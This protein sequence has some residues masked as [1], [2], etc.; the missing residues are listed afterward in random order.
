MAYYDWRHRSYGPRRVL[1]GS[2]TSK[3]E[4]RSVIP[5][6]IPPGQIIRVA[7][8]KIP[9]WIY[10]GASWHG[11]VPYQEEL[12]GSIIDLNARAARRS[13]QTVPITPGYS[14]VYYHAT[15]LQRGCYLDWLATGR[16]DDRIASQYISLFL[17]SLEYRFFFD[18][19]AEEQPVIRAEAQRLRALYVAK[20]PARSQLDAFI[21]ATGVALGAQWE[22]EIVP[23]DLEHPLE[24]T[25]GWRVALGNAVA[26]GAPLCADW[27]LG[28]YLRDPGRRP[29]R[30][31]TK[32]L[33]TEY[34]CLFRE[35]FDDQY[36]QGLTVLAEAPLKYSYTAASGSFV[37]NLSDHLK[38]TPDV[39]KLKTTFELIQSIAHDTT[40]ALDKCS[41]YLGRN[42]EKRGSIHAHLLLPP[43]IRDQIPCTRLECF[44]QWADAVIKTEEW[45]TYRALIHRYE[46]S[47]DGPVPT[48]AAVRRAVADG[49]ARLG[50]GLAS[51]PA[52]GRDDAKLYDPVLLFRLPS[53]TKGIPGRY[54]YG[55]AL[56]AVAIGSLVARADGGVTTEAMHILQQALGSF[57]LPQIERSFVDN[58]LKWAL[59]V[60]PERAKFG[61]AGRSSFS[62]RSKLCTMAL[63]V[64]TANECVT[65]ATESALRR[66]YRALGFTLR[67]MRKDLRALAPA[68]GPVTVL[69]Q[70]GL[71]AG[72]IVPRRS[73]KKVSLDKDRIDALAVETAE[74]ATVLTE[75]L[76]V[77]VASG[78]QEAGLRPSNGG[79]EEGYEPLLQELKKGQ[80]WRE[81]EL[82]VLARQCGLTLAT[83]LPTL[84]DWSYEHFNDV[85]LE[86]YDGSYEVNEDVMEEIRNG[87]T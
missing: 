11:G 41:R 28:W 3:K 78:D 42:P 62:I 55:V 86:L 75:V 49:L 51:Y 17:H 84:N 56:N 36:P 24:A 72:Y 23:T 5:R 63:Y 21:E 47:L 44:V 45:P 1:R 46:G 79:L 85:L 31:P 54:L 38:H 82:D 15:N 22:D 18:C 29:L 74:V 34:R 4:A 20:N 71:D 81:D 77:E 76:D 19:P 57:K 48:T 7:G 60:P 64:A 35:S 61:M 68:I 6:W 37:Y 13:S 80:V 16:T 67:D 14:L 39:S 65:A 87:L 30:V 69:V 12:G 8:R 43:Q 52:Y 53:A 32:R 10:V 59:Q 9:G 40:A 33:Y 26:S 73:A 27:A 25:L 70:Q 58:Y 66:V 83:A 2:T 50:F